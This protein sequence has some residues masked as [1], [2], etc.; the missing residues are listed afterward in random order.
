MDA[1]LLS[2]RLGFPTL[3]SRGVSRFLFFKTVSPHFLRYK[4]HTPLLFKIMS[5]VA[6]TPGAVARIR[7]S[8]EVLKDELN[9]QVCFIFFITHRGGFRDVVVSR[10]VWGGFFLSFFLSSSKTSSATKKFHQQNV[11]FKKLTTTFFGL[12][13]IHPGSRF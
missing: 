1:V 10:L 6:V 2:T 3:I 13:F 4:L 11:S 12:L 7:E 9:V 8:K 5:A